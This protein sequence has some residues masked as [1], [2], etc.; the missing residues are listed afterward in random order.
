LLKKEDKV[1]FRI[2]QRMDETEP[3]NDKVNTQGRITQYA[4]E[5]VL[6]KYRIYS[7]PFTDFPEITSH[8]HPHLALYDLCEKIDRLYG[9][10]PYDWMS[11]CGSDYSH[12]NSIWG[13]YKAW[14]KVKIP[15]KYDGAPGSGSGS[16][17]ISGSS[18]PPASRPC[19]VAR[20][21][22]RSTPSRQSDGVNTR[23]SIPYVEVGSDGSSDDD[24]DDGE[25]VEESWSALKMRVHLWKSSIPPGLES[26]HSTSCQEFLDA[27]TIQKA[28]SRESDGSGLPTA[29]S[30]PVDEKSPSPSTSTISRRSFSGSLATSAGSHRSKRARTANPDMEKLNEQLSTFNSTFNH[31]TL[32]KTQLRDQARDMILSL[33]RDYLGNTGMLAMLKYLDSHPNPVPLIETYVRLAKEDMLRRQWL[34]EIVVETGIVLAD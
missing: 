17:T 34:R 23:D 29:P 20:A 1:K 16:H 10:A 9:Q 32:H 22:K 33:D 27:L 24:D 5:T 19:Q 3:D 12:L 30:A 14:M 2:I 13:V 31:A 26:E 28:P 4:D 18:R 11:K 15:P 8:M 21:L 25:E 6:H 7:P